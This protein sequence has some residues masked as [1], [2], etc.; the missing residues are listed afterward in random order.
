MTQGQA[1]RATGE[2]LS[3][4]L[5]A[6]SAV[7]HG[8]RKH[9]SHRERLAWLASARDVARRVDGLVAALLS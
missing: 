1:V 6:L 8:A 3:S 9:A 2:V 7:D 4:V 5:A